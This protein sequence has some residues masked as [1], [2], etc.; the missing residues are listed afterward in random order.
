[1]PSQAEAPAAVKIWDWPT[2]L[3]HWALAVCI[4]A[5]WVTA[6]AFDLLA[7]HM[8]LGYVTLG[9]VVFRIAWGVVG[10]RHARFASFVRGPGAVVRYARTL[11][12]RD[13]TP[14]PGHNPLGALAILLMLGMLALQATTG[15]FATD[16]LLYVGPYNG[17]VPTQTGEALTSLH[18]RNGGFIPWVIALHLSAVLWYTLFKGQNLVG[19][20]IT[21]MKRERAVAREHAIDNSRTGL[22]L[23]LAGIV[24]AAVW[25]LVAF[26]PPPAVPEGLF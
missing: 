26:A 16:E 6:N 12:R 13:S 17:A 14:S 4:P 25:A 23:L 3:V 21:G 10:P 8:V 24:A 11:G 7:I 22:A 15:L 5:S 9:L 19:A 1:M 20:M 2:R 18:K